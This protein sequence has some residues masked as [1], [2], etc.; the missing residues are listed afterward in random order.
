MENSFFFN[1]NIIFVYFSS[2]KCNLVEHDTS[3]Q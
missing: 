3:K 2:D 1:Y